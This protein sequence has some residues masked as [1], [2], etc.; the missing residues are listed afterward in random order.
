M[1]QRSKTN[2]AGLDSN[3]RREYWYSMLSLFPFAFFPILTILAV[4][5]GLI[6]PYFS[7]SVIP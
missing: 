6:V 3:P 1:T 5:S 4:L 7:A 2:S